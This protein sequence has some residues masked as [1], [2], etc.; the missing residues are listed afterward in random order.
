MHQ[1]LKHYWGRWKQL[2]TDGWGLLWY[3][4]ETKIASCQWKLVIPI[5][6]HEATI[7]ILQD[8]PIGGHLCK[9]RSVARLWQGPVYWHQCAN[10]LRWHCT[11]CDAMMS[12]QSVAV[13]ILGPLSQSV[14]GNQYILVF[15]DHFSQWVALFA[16]PDHTGQGMVTKVSRSTNS[17]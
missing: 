7:L 1:S 15:M 14:R 17:L 13:N 9:E 2:K 12:F 4:W 11:T 16:L 3:R 10:D 6:Y 8:S 5:V